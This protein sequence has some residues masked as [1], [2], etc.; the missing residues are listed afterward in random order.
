VSA[1]EGEF[2]RALRAAIDEAMCGCIPCDGGRITSR[3][4]VHH[5]FVRIMRGEHVE[6]VGL[7][8]VIDDEWVLY[9]ES[10]VEQGQMRPDLSSLPP[11]T[12]VKYVEVVDYRRPSAVSLDELKP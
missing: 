7:A 9:C 1:A 4:M 11:G 6:F 5:P 3:C 2:E 10:P 12:Q 8:H